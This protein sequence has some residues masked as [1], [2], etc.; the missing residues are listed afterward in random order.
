MNIKLEDYIPLLN[1]IA[2]TVHK[3][4]GG[5]IEIIKSITYE[6]A[7]R[8]TR[9]Y[10]SSKMPNFATFLYAY[11]PS[12]VYKQ[13]CERVNDDKLDKYYDISSLD[14]ELDQ[15]QS[16][17]DTMEQTL[18]E[19]TTGDMLNVD[20]LLGELSKVLSKKQLEVVYWISRGYNYTEIASILGITKQAIDERMKKV[21]KRVI[22]EY[23]TREKLL[24]KYVDIFN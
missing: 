23:Q 24:E 16:I 19:P 11:I 9:C 18:Y 10:D 7:V 5:D 20:S 12:Q 1:K 4:V 6:V 13:V 15:G 17:S 8:T 2:F 14:I 22:E 21:R 3:R